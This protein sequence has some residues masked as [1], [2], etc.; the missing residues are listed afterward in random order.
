M[1]V[2]PP[3]DQEKTW[4]IIRY[5]PGSGAFPRDDAAAFDG[6]YSDRNDALAV[7]RDW[8]ARHPQ[9]IVALVRSD[10]IWFGDGDF[11]EFRRRPLTRREQGLAEALRAAAQARATGRDHAR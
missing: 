11:S 1:T 7:A 10:L 3:S 5:A 4:G 9:W 2:T 6:W 8:V